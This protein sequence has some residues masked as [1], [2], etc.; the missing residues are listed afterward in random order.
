MIRLRTPQHE[1]AEGTVAW[2]VSSTCTAA[3]LRETA[4][5]ERGLRMA[6]AARYTAL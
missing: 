2:S 5:F 1:A 3:R 4:P 6:L